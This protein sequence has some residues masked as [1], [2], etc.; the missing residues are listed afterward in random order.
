MPRYE[1]NLCLLFDSTVLCSTESNVITLGITG[2]ADKIICIQS[3]KIDFPGV[4]AIP[5]KQRGH[6]FIRN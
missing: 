1:S 2:V 5:N 6:L 4:V 3:T